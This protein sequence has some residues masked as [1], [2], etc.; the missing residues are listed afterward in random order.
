M[1]IVFTESFRE[2]VESEVDD[3]PVQHWE[4]LCL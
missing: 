4:Q 1:S 2:H 3:S